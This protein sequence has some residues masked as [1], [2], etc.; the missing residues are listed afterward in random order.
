M[1][2]FCPE[3]FFF[4][5][6][7]ADKWKQCCVCLLAS[8]VKTLL[9]SEFCHHVFYP[10]T[11]VCSQQCSFQI[12]QNLLNNCETKT[13]VPK[14]QTVMRF[15][16]WTVAHEY[17]ILEV[18]VPDDLIRFDS[19]TFLKSLLWNWAFVGNRDRCFAAQVIC[20][21]FSRCGQVRAKAPVM[22][23]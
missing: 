13:G 7:A 16:W 15:L 18:R 12:S 3:V 20:S 19:V 23:Y 21:P 4:I 2:T 5:S 17:L 22:H 1:S 10:N 11:W 6:M 9:G 8:L 14:L